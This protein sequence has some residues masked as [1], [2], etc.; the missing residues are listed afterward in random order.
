MIISKI[1]LILKGILFGA[2]NLIPGA[3]GGTTLVA[4]GIY[5]D[6]IKSISSLK[7]NFKKSIIFLLFL[8]IGTAI[9]VVTGS[10]L[11]KKVLL[12]SIP[13]ITY[14][15]FGGFIVGSLPNL[16][17]PHIKKINVLYVIG[18]LISLGVAIGLMILGLNL[19]TISL[20]FG[21][22]LQFKDYLLL[23]VCGFVGIFMMLIPGVSGILI[24]LILGYYN[25]FIDAINNI[26][27][28]AS[29]VDVIKICL[30]V[31]LGILVGIIPAALLIR[32]LLKKF[33]TGIYFCIFGFV[34]G[35][36]IDL[37]ISYFTQY[38]MPDVLNWILGIVA[39]I[40][41]S[42]LSYIII[43]ISNDKM[44]KNNET[45]DINNN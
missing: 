42:V 7:S 16:I 37:Y 34:V 19:D 33:P 5:E 10:L 26:F 9:G 28:F 11:I 15:I 20:S 21:D 17:A 3:S 27:H 31:G 29:I 4:C 44:V 39:L 2:S 30:P 6:T 32:L 24:F 40:S 23:F 45:E 25:V 43:K 18:F 35:S 41:F 36:I 13:F 38:P 14:C 1:I 22:S 12:A 8:L